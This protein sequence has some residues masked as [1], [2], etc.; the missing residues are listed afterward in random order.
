MP[1][2]LYHHENFDGSGYPHGLKGEAI[3]IGAR[4][5]RMVDALAALLHDRP[6]R[7]GVGVEEAVK[8]LREGVGIRFCPT[9]SEAFLAIA[10][11]H[12]TE[13]G[14]YRFE[15]DVALQAEFQ[16]TRTKGPELSIS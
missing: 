1:Y 7:K 9:V 6:F 3:P 10:T 5:I 14:K 16:K 12:K 2:I 4:I 13:L 8:L 15:G 11:E